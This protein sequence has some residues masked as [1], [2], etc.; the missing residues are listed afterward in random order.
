VKKDI[1]DNLNNLVLDVSKDYGTAT[2]NEKNDLFNRIIKGVSTVKEVEGQSV[3]NSVKRKQVKLEESKQELERDKLELERSKVNNDIRKIGLEESKINFEM[4]RFEATMN[5]ETLKLELENAKFGFEK[6][7]Y[8][9]EL[10]KEKSDRRY[11]TIIKCIEIGL[12][13]FVYGGLSIL[14]LK[15]IY[16][17]DERIPSD[18]WNFI[19]GVLRKK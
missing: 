9:H 17:D 7:K 18:T 12:P 3:E 19:K 8:E 6:L 10:S 13:L 4:K 15:A 1:K 16:K 11:N 5:N 2:P 14:S